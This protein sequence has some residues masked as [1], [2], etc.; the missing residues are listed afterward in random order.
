MVTKKSREKSS[1]KKVVPREKPTLFEQE[2]PII[3]GGGG[4]T[5]VFI[6]NDVTQIEKKT[7]GHY[8]RYTYNVDTDYVTVFEDSGSFGNGYRLDK[9]THKVP[10]WQPSQED[11][12]KPPRP[13]RKKR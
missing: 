13:K 12:P 4:S 5:Y 9:K 10:F 11:R 8:T 2:P 7:M 3:V 6:R 1:T